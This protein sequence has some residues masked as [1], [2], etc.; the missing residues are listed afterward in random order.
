MR[1]EHLE[2][3]V[4]L[5]RT[6]S[7]TQTA[8]NFYISQPVLSR[9]ISSLERE[10]NAK[11]FVRDQHGA[12]LTEA[13][14][15]FLKDAEVTVECYRTMIGNLSA[16]MRIESC[17]T[18]GFLTGAAMPFIPRAHMLFAKKHS[19]IEPRYVT[20]EFNEAYRKLDEGEVDLIITGMPKD[21]SPS[22]Y[23]SMRLFEDS[24]FAVMTKDHPLSGKKALTP[25]E[26]RGET[27]LVPTRTFFAANTTA[28]RQYLQPEENRIHV[29]EV[30]RDMNT[31][32]VMLES[33]N[34]IGITL[35]HLRRYYNNDNFAYVPLEGFPMSMTIGVIWKKGVDSAEVRDYANAFSRSVKE[36]GQLPPADE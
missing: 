32:P 27:V 35:G 15:S 36:L 24:Y 2:E 16:R 10:I 34:L 23:E 12:R 25:P 28:F 20:C 7:F 1:I 30:I 11:L 21:L 5:G 8:R 22:L 6:L 4:D 13:G 26:L 19:N 18:V 31:L 29:S 17:I 33:E 3:C 9:H 14:K